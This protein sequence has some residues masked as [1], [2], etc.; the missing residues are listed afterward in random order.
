MKSKSFFEEM[1]G[2]YTKVGDYYFPNLTVPAEEE[3]FSFG[4]YG[5]MRLD[6]LKEYHPGIYIDLLTTGELPKHLHEVD[7]QAREQ[8]E[9][10]VAAM[11]KA[12]GCDEDLKARDPMR[13]VGLMNNYKVCAED[14]ILR[15]IIYQ[16]Y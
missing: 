3:T 5:H 8:V 2:T 16:I 12:E 14:A 13:W 1:G 11:A 10:I 6:Y 7:Q 4:K 9:Q 15:E